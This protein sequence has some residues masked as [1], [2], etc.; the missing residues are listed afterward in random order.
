MSKLFSKISV[1]MSISSLSVVCP[2]CNQVISYDSLEEFERRV[3]EEELFK[4]DDLYNK[5]VPC[6]N[7]CHDITINEIYRDIN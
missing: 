7:C 6:T 4:T 3:L 5:I 1:Q 2:N